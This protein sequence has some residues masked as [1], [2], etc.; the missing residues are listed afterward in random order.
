M[1]KKILVIEDEVELGNIIQEYLKR[2]KYQAIHTSDA[3]NCIEIIRKE[4]PDLILSDLLL[5]K[6]H[7]FDIC[8]TLKSDPQL[9]EIPLIVMTGVYKSAAFKDKADEIGVEEFIAKP[10]DYK[11]LLIKIK[12][13]IGPGS[14]TEVEAAEPEM[15]VRPGPEEKKKIK[16]FIK[17]QLLELRQDFA[18]RL[19]EKVMELE[20]IWECVLQRK[21]T[22]KQLAKFRKLVHRIIGT[23]HNLGF[24]ELTDN[25][26][27]LEL[28]V[29]MIMIEGEETIS[30]RKH[31]IDQLLD[32]LRHHPLVTTG[33]EVSKQMD[34]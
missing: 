5:P 9:K 21:N 1:G 25:S 13:F 27:E 28:I 29:D 20:R 4:Q 18:S 6:V 17:E 3:V 15:L 19:P 7:G 8:I 34:D 16:N 26:M 12:K 32:N 23:G 22:K 33:I 24:K 2:H 30:K 10:L 31:K 14:A 11:D